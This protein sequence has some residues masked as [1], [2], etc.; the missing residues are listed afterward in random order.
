MV[1]RWWANDGPLLVLFGSSL[2]SSTKLEDLKVLR[3]SPDH[4]NNV[5][6]VQGQLQLIMEQILFYHI[7]G[8][9]P[10]WSSAIKY[11]ADT[12]KL[13]KGYIFVAVLLGYSQYWP[14]GC[15]VLWF[16]CPGTPE[17]STG[18]GSGFKRLR[19]RAMV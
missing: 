3:R 14:G 12:A 6:I 2:L 11:L 4:L 13:Q 18:S 10:F 19:K 9:Q 5:K 1:F 7:W 16:I 8:L 15:M 17:G